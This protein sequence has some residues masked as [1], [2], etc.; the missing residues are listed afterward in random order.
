[1]MICKD[2]SSISKLHCKFVPSNAWR[3][4]IWQNLATWQ[5]TRTKQR[6]TYWLAFHQVIVNVWLLQVIFLCHCFFCLSVSW[7]TFW[8]SR[9]TAVQAHSPWLLS[10]W[11][12]WIARWQ[13]NECHWQLNQGLP[14]TDDTWLGLFDGSPDPHIRVS[15][16]ADF[17]FFNIFP[18]NRQLT[19]WG[20][21]PCFFY[22]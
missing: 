17:L 3:R 16:W 7:S 15:C 19:S 13:K 6:Q 12:C 4:D 18:L 11:L 22:I 10:K 2:F 14:D 9:R 20:W 1:M 8:T 5:E 21:F